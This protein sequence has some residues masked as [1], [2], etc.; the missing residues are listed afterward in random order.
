MRV[1]S[2]MK[3]IVFVCVY[4]YI[5]ISVLQCAESHN[6]SL[7]R[8]YLYQTWRQQRRSQASFCSSLYYHHPGQQPHLS[9]HVLS[10]ECRGHLWCWCTV[11]RPPGSTLVI[12]IIMFNRVFSSKLWIL[13]TKRMI[14]RWLTS[15][16]FAHKGKTTQSISYLSQAGFC[17]EF[18]VDTFGPLNVH[19]C[20]PSLQ[21]SCLFPA[22]SYLYLDIS[23]VFVWIHTS[24]SDVCHTL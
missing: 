3:C 2:D 18:T 5:Y 6:I 13:W 11:L 14:K 22:V 19:H 12:I 21:T 9:D 7:N 17:R 24:D 16:P 23:I 15:Y 10:T 20:S 4:I 1:L 8:L